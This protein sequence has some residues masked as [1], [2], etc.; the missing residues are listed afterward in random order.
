MLCIKDYMI[1]NDW[2]SILDSYFKS[3]VFKDLLNKI[4]YE[5]RNKIIYPPKKD[6][7]NALMI[8]PFNNVKVVILGQ[9]PYHGDDEA[10]GL[11]F[12]V[13]PGI[14]MPPSLKNIFKELQNDLDIK[15]PLSGNLTLWGKEGVLLL[16][17]SLTVIKDKPN[18]HQ[19]IGWDKL[20][21]LI[22]KKLNAKE[23]PVVFILWGN[24]AKGKKGLITNPKHLVLESSHPSPLSANRGFF[25]SKP[26]SKTNEF[27]IKNNLIPINWE[28]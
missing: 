12:S 27:L 3:S 6:L 18:S 5:Y 13:K 8:T 2:D 23:S 20:T 16:N 22:I 17:T 7:F 21:D 28:I 25:G 11:A 9:D 15:S 26:F 4:N 1:G 10:H 14:K 19:D 24:Y